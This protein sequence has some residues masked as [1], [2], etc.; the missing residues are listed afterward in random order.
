MPR[1]V[2][3]GGALVLAA[4]VACD[5]R[6]EGIPPAGAR[7]PVFVQVGP[8]PGP[9]DASAAPAAR[10]PLAGR[11]DARENGRRLFV[12]FN[13]AGCHGGHGGGGMGPS[14]RD[15]EWIYGSSDAHIFDSIAAGRAH[16]MPAWGTQVPSEQIWELVAYIRSMRTDDEPQPPR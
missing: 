13:C 1:A 2:V 11:A 4:A 3:V 14:L 16:G 15:V 5:M 8:V 12:W 6:P 7:P 9:Q 10:N